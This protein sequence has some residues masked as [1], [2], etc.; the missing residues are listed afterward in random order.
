MVAHLME[1]LM[2]ANSPLTQAH[3]ISHPAACFRNGLVRVN[4]SARG[5]P[6]YGSPS[7]SPGVPYRPSGVTAEPEARDPQPAR[8]GSDMRWQGPAQR[9]RAPRHPPIAG[10]DQ[11]GG[12]QEPQRPTARG[13]HRQRR[14]VPGR[15]PRG[16]PQPAAHQLVGEHRHK[17]AAPQQFLTGGIYRRHTG[18]GCQQH[19][20]GLAQLRHQLGAHSPQGRHKQGR[21]SQPAGL[22]NGRPA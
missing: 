6:D 17:Q 5:R 11:R 15:E 2:P 10:P 1:L 14:Q 7:S 8:V 21:G 20:V 13:Q 9:P 18:G 4:K 12:N 3:P 16:R 22:G 19:R